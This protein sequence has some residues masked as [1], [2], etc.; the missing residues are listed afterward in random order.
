MIDLDEETG[1]GTELGAL[2]PVNDKSAPIYYKDFNS[3]CIVG[4]DLIDK[5]ESYV[6]CVL[7]DKLYKNQDQ[8]LNNVGK[9]EIK[10]GNIKVILNKKKNK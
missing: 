8:K 10:K 9:V 2:M 3:D 6:R 1:E 7:S 4:V 5:G